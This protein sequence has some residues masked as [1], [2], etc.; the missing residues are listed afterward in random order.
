MKIIGVFLMSSG[1]YFTHALKHIVNRTFKGIHVPAIKISDGLI[2]I[3]LIVDLVVLNIFA[4][5]NS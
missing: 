4:K 5:K 2:H 3:V 1:K